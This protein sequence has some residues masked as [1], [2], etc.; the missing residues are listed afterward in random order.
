MDERLLRKW[1]PRIAAVE[2]VRRSCGRTFSDS[3]AQRMVTLLENADQ[4]MRRAD[5]AKG[6]KPIENVNEAVQTTDIVHGLKLQ[7][8]DVITGVFPN[9]I[10]EELVSIQPLQQKTGQIFY[11]KYVRGNNKG[12]FQKGETLMD[13]YETTGYENRNWTSE[14]VEEEP[15]QVAG[16]DTQFVLDCVPVRPGTVEINGIT[17]TNIDYATGTVTF[18]APGED[19]TVTVNYQCDLEYAPAQ[20]IP[21]IS[22]EMYD[23]F[24]T[25]RPHKLKAFFSL[26]A[27][28]DLQMAQGIDVADSLLQAAA[29]EMRHETDGD[30][31]MDI[32]NKT[33]KTSTWNN[34]YHHDN[35]D[36]ITYRE[37][38]Q[39][40]AD[41]IHQASTS[42]FQSTK[43]VMANWVV[44]G[45]QGADLLN[46][47]GAP[48][49]VGSGVSAVGPHFAGTL[50]GNMR[51]YFDP[52]LP[53]DAYLVGYKG[54]QLMD[55]GYVYAPYM[56]FYATDLIMLDDFI[57]R[58][59]FATSYGKR[60]LVP[61]LYRKGKI[62]RFATDSNGNLTETVGASARFA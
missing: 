28:Y 37:Y 21:E 31:I 32:F 47:I 56:L 40:F 16:A 33:V 59:G 39:T 26:D 17:A 13:Q 29:A 20:G 57:G 62:T 5:M 48:R 60:M 51:V 54:E 14:F 58:R 24:I 50:D 34:G 23:T 3:E 7:T 9:L 12:K 61:E 45:K 19:T 49:F 52:F 35:T 25:A 55:T 44:V 43:R 18:V 4:A 27:A 42:I 6:R 38:C 30:I 15:H 53:Q 2:S 8:F 1:A 22:L 46:V 36:G 10:A 11:L 41:E